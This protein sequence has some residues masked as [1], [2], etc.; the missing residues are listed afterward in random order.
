MVTSCCGENECKAFAIGDTNLLSKRKEK[1]DEV[2]TL[3]TLYLVLKL[4]VAQSS[5]AEEV[6]KIGSVVT[7]NNNDTVSIV[8]SRAL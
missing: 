7:I 1:R 3:Y 4:M 2:S 5:V 8:Q 6:A